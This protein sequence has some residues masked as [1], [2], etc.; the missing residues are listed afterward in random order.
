MKNIF[1]GNLDLQTT[2]ESIRSFFEPIGTVHKVKLMLDRKTGQSRGFAFI[3]MTE[4]EADK[5]IAALHGKALDGRAVD[6]HEGRQRVYGPASTEQV[7]PNDAAPD[8]L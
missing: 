3:E 8:H 4:P 2:V 6:V 1:V 7:I 5:A